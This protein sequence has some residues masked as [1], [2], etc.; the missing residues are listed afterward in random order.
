MADEHHV[1]NEASQLKRKAIRDL[2]FDK[3]LSP[4]ERT[5]QIQLIMSGK[6]KPWAEQQGT[7]PAAAT[8]S[9]EMSPPPPQSTPPVTSVVKSGGNGME[10]A[11]KPP[12]AASAFEDKLRAKMN[13]INVRSSSRNLQNSNEP[14][15]GKAIGE[16]ANSGDNP[17]NSKF[18]DRPNSYQTLAGGNRRNPESSDYVEVDTIGGGEDSTVELGTIGDGEDGTVELGT[19]GDSEASTVE[20]GTIGDSEASELGTLGGGEDNTVELGT[21]GDDD[22]LSSLES[23]SS[24][25]SRNWSNRFRAAALEAKIA[26]KM[27]KLGADNSPKLKE[28]G[29]ESDGEYTFENASC[30][31]LELNEQGEPSSSQGVGHD[32]LPM[33]DG[34]VRDEE[35][36]MNNRESTVSLVENSSDDIEVL[37]NSF[38]PSLSM[39]GEDEPNFPNSSNPDGLAVATAVASDDEPDYVFQAVE[40]DPDAKPPLHKNRRF[41]VY[42]Y[43]ALFLIFIVFVLVVVYITSMTKEAEVKDNIIR[44]TSQP[45]PKAT[46]PP[47]TFREAQGLIEQLQDGVLLRNENFEDMQVTDPRVMA[48]D[49]ILHEDEQRL[50]SDSINLYQ[51]YGLA[52]LAY[53]MDSKAWFNCG[54]PG[55]N[56]TETSCSIYS[57]VMNQTVDYGVWLSGESE[58]DW[59]GVKC[60]GDG[61]VRSVTLINNNL[62]GVLPHE[63]TA[64]RFLQMLALAGNCIY[65]TIPEEIGQLDH[66]LSLELHENGLSGAMPSTIYQLEKL[67][68]LNLAKQYGVDRVCQQSNGTKIYTNYKHGG[69]VREFNV[70]LT[71]KLGS[72][73]GKWKSMKG[74][75]LSENSFTG[76]IAEDIGNLRYLTFLH[77]NDNFIEGNLPASITKLRNLRHLQFHDNFLYTSLPEGIGNMKD[78]ERLSVNGNS[79]FGKLPEGMYDLKKLKSLF[80][81]DTAEANS[82]WLINDQEGFSGSL[83]SSVGRLKDLEYLLLNNNPITGEIPS[84]LGNCTKLKVLRLHRTELKGSMPRE[85]CMLRDKDLNNENGV[86]VLYA[87]CR[88]NNRT[89][90]P[91]VQ[92]DCCTDCCDYTTNV[93]VQDD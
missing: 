57:S 67:Q 8:T 88:P 25:T 21:I 54:N 55:E 27:G 69:F 16:G 46:S 91:R 20:L 70:G 93:C 19:I 85:V 44:L 14:M 79:M 32:S 5:K 87:D 58:C 73:V 64:L 12:A 3:S 10:G 60:S 47:T 11:D 39:R 77:V 66:L 48:L 29:E 65:G 59:F 33:P 43:F 83:S 34:H 13:E 78:L 84:D 63:L 80:L 17:L 26:A 81:H 37:R 18:D 62:V 45:T 7:A 72:E 2:M 22:D 90:E 1:E 38:L 71:G 74:M 50:V 56:F 75:Y 23:K 28:D 35:V 49:W 31:T 24:F 52:V 86:G 82:P 15:G 92:C 40:Y 36:P 6:I 41:R 61:I 30:F 51:R 42:T 4:S 53:A 89:E 76:E 68:L 9:S